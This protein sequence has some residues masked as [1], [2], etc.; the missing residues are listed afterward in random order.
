MQVGNGGAREFISAYFITDLV[1]MLVKE[2]RAL[3]F[4]PVYFF[5]FFGGT[6]LDLLIL[7]DFNFLGVSSSDSKT[8][9]SDLT[10]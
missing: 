1:L 4:S 7:N 8:I 10:E 5:F 9:S 6:L 3:E 2:R